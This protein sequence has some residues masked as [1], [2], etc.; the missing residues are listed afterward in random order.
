MLTNTTCHTVCLITWRTVFSGQTWKT[1]LF[2]LFVLVPSFG[3]CRAAAQQ[4]DFVCVSSLWADGAIIFSNT[5]GYVGGPCGLTNNVL[6]RITT[7]N[8]VSG[9]QSRD[10]YGL[11]QP[12]LAAPDALF[13]RS[14]T[15]KHCATWDK[16]GG[17]KMG[18]KEE[19]TYY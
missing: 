9:D 4:I 17:V 2:G 1:E 3:A 6:S 16:E 8:F 19:R 10:F 18:V 7:K 12:A 13:E 15:F 14:S 11:F 5:V